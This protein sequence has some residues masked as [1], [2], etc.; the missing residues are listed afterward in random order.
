M[1]KVTRRES[2]IWLVGATTLAATKSKGQNNNNTTR[3]FQHGVA[4][5]DPARD[6]VV[7]WT[8]VTTPTE[9]MTIAWE[10]ARDPSFKSIVRRG[11]T[12]SRAVRDHTVKVVPE[13]LEPGQTYYYR[14]RA[15]GESSPPGRTK[16]LPVGAL[17]RLGIALMSCSNYSL[18]YFT[19]YD[20]VAADTNI[21]FVLHT[22]DYIYEY[23]NDTSKMS[24]YYVRPSEPPHQ[25]VTLDDYRKRHATNKTDPHS[26]RMHATH[27][28]IAFWDDHDVANDD[29]SGGAENHHPATEG[30]WRVRRDAAIQAYFEWMPIRDP[31]PGHSPLDYWR[32]YSF[33]DLAT[34]V[35]LETRL[36]A[37]GKQVDYHEF[38]DTVH[39][40]ADRAAFMKNVLGDPSRQMM[41]DGMKTSLKEGLAASVAQHQ[42]WRLV[43]NGVLMAKIC[44]PDLRRHGLRPEDYPELALLDKYAGILWDADHNVPDTTD[45][46][47]GYSGAREE[48]YEICQSVGVRDLLVLTGDSHCFWS[49]TLADDQ[50][51]AMGI[52]LGTAGISI[53]SDFALAGFRPA[54]MEKL[55]KLYASNNVEVN[56]TDSRHRGY[57]RVLLGRESA[58]VDFVAID[59]TIQQ[60]YSSTILRSETIHLRDGTLK[61]SASA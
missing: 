43:G 25:T 40:P 15:Q 28:M 22:G 26:Q 42:P 33:G 41:S 5:G 56:W 29:W 1:N 39:T 52:E 13:G 45:N 6:S 32:T 37:R 34:L 55:D 7:L 4:S 18:G 9:E 50:G 23:S 14:F 8:R 38:K 60:N 3:L 35:T 2:V 46:W 53:P 51:S 44:T 21:D 24:N 49:N 17:D 16:T 12:S 54:L 57:V 27:P 10:L 20:A 31:A 59:T 36:T 30:D 11:T 61:S 58:A 48:F 19:T 47:N